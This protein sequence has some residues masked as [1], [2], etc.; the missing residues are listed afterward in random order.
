MFQKFIALGRKAF[1][2]AV[3]GLKATGAKVGTAMVST[4]VAVDAMAADS[5]MVIAAKAGVD[6]AKADGGAIGGYVVGAVAILVGVGLC[7][8]MVK[9]L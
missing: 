7:I 1:N 6:A 3:D 8:A 9:K 4:A 2:G 5:D